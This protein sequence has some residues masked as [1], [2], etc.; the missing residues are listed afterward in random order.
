MSI[1]DETSCLLGEGPLWHPE[2]EELFWFD[3]LGRTLHATGR[4]QRLPGLAS[5]AGWVDRDTLLVAMGDALH[6][7][8]I[9]TDA[10]E[11]VAVVDASPLTRFNDGRADP[12]GGFWISR[13]GLRTEAEAGGIWRYHRGEV[14]PLFDRITIPNAIC[15]DPEGRFACFADTAKQTVWSVPLDRDGWPQGEPAVFLDLRGEGLDPDGAVMDA[16]GTIWVA[17]WGKGE[18]AG[19]RD[20]VRL[21]AHA[22]A[23]VQTT[24]PALGGP[25]LSTLFV[26][27]AAVGIPQADIAQAPD[28]GRTFAI[29]TAIRGVPEPQ[30]IL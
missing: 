2:R 23:A 17:L 11:A 7:H 25:S 24:C 3:I 18:V 21:G 19:Y 28:Q 20:G 22:V 15:F 5:A 12:Q 4:R 29:E 6:R 14:R 1:H 10:F 16:G 13:M 26:T 8:V 27:S 30:V 9:G